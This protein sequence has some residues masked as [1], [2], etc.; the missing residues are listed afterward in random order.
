MRSSHSRGSFRQQQS[1]HKKNST[2]QIKEQ[3]PHATVVGQKDQRQPNS[4]GLPCLNRVISHHLFSK[5]NTNT[6][7]K[8]DWFWLSGKGK[9]GVKFDIEKLRSDSFFEK[10]KQYYEGK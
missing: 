7:D 9:K 5:A 2:A 8:G 10:H 1:I 3:L 6:G 4:R